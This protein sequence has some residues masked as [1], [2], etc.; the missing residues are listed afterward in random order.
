MGKLGV[1]AVDCDGHVFEQDW[2]WEK[3]MVGPIR[4]LRPR[5]VLD[6]RG[7]KRTM[8]EGRLYPTPEG[9]GVGNFGGLDN[10]CSRPGGYDPHERLKDMDADG[11]DIHVLFPGIAMGFQGIR[12]VELAKAVCQAY[13]DWLYD[14]TLANP[15]RLK[16]IAVVPLQDPQAAA[17]E[18]RRMVK[19]G[20]VGIMVGPWVGQEAKQLDHP[21]HYPFWAEVQELGVPVCPHAATAFNLPYPGLNWFVT[22]FQTHMISHSFAQMMA[23]TSLVA[24]GIVERFPRLKILFCEAGCGWYPYW[25]DRMDEHYENMPEDQLNGLKMKP[26][27]YFER[28]CWVTCEPEEEM[29]GVV[30]KLVGDDKVMMATDYPHW[31]MQEEKHYRRLLNR[32]DIPRAT[33]EKVMGLNAAKLFGLS[34]PKQ[35]NG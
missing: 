9:P 2:I 22:N 24:G 31:D 30:A 8:L 6:N 12:N 28:Q 13:N 3:Y 26:S 21:D 15:E 25:I 33:R 19:K 16:G 11:L 34:E 5:T 29:I 32:E 14:F 27:E 23:A 20:L 35:K 10:V 1:F 18:A 7:L 4:E 17:L